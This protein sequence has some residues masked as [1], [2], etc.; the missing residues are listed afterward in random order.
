MVLIAAT[1][2]VPL[3]GGLML[4]VFGFQSRRARAWYVE[5]VTLATSA[6]AVALCLRRPAGTLT[7]LHMTDTFTLALR[8]DGLSLAFTGL[9]AFL[10][11]LATLYAFEYMAHENREN[12]FFC[13]YTLS[14]AA[15]LAISMA[16]NL[17]TLY[18]FYES[19]TLATLPLV[20]HKRDVKSIRAGR[21]YLL[22]SLGGAALAF[23]GMMVLSRFGAGHDFVPGGTLKSVP[24]GRE[25]LLRVMFVLAFL[26]FS[27]K[28]A[29]FPLYAWLPA[30]SVAPTPV[31][32]LLHA[33]A[34]VNA[35]AYACMRLI[36]YCYGTELLS[37]T[38]AQ[39]VALA[40]AAFTIVFGSAMAVRE[41]HF[42]RRLAYS[43]VSNLSYILL[44]AAL[45]TPAGLTGALT[46]MICHGLMK[47]TLFYCAGA[48]LVKTEQEYV[49]DLRG[50]GKVMPFTF[51]VFTLAALALVGVPPLCGFISKWNLLSAA[52]E[53]GLTMGFVGIAALVISAVLTAVYM[54]SVVV[55]AY[56]MPLNADQAALAGQ[57]RDPSWLMKAP[58]LVISAAIVA[59]GLSGA[60]L[61][62]FLSDIANNLL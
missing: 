23:A 48:V 4:P 21:K 24:A 25:T 1:L 15:T 58:L 53:S 49:Q 11:P 34:V 33:V 46:H 9:I 29:M 55:S 7:L 47:I 42:K 5:A 28:A 2:L 40:L 57:N 37:G 32:A 50:F 43:T 31:T 35:G 36:Y 30:A 52:A 61:T 10:W 8:V 59:L 6:L 26:G 14:Y 13:Y 20:T 56:F 45:M 62:Q 27:V 18:V 44:G 54:M 22:Y 51:A 19:L 16:A 60:A 17:F 3:L 39:T 38:W 12:A 41:Q